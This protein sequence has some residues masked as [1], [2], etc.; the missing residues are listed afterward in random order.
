MIIMFIGPSSS[1]KDTFFN[2][3]AEKYNLENIVLHTTRP[4]RTGEVDGIN[5]H[6]VSMDTLND[7]DNNNLLI[8]RRN[9]DTKYGIWSYATSSSSIDL[10]KDYIILNTWEGY[11]KFIEYYG[12]DIVVPF[13]FKLDDYIRLKRALE[14]ERNDE[15]PKYDE[16]C[17][18]YLADKVD[19][20]ES[21]LKKYNPY[22]IDNNG[23]MEETSKQIDNYMNLVLKRKN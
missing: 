23:T 5:Y 10:S 20:D 3:S 4:I 8:E 22:I 1:G 15:N 11:K 9:Y 21:Y 19:F 6:F 14:R 18:R 12:A 13:Y 17:R 16:M 2:K 7:M